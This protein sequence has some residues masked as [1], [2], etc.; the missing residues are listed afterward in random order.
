MS[1]GTYS[2]RDF[3]ATSFVT[4]AWLLRRRAL[5]QPT[6]LTS[7]SLEAAA[8]LVRSKSAEQIAGAIDEVLQDKRGPLRGVVHCWSLDTAI[9]DSASANEL[10]ASQSAGCETGRRRLADDGLIF[11][12]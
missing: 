3:V 1:G 12:L 5:P 10:L 11:R 4:S 2:R 9:T 6:D 7:L 8:K